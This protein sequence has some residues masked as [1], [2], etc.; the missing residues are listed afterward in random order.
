MWAQL[1]C[2]LLGICLMALPSLLGYGRP[3]ATSDWIIG[4]LAASWALVA[5]WEITRAVRWVNV[6]LAAWIVLS[7]VVLGAEM[8]GWVLFGHLVVGLSIGSLSALRGHRKHRFAGGWRAIWGRT[9]PG[10]Q[11]HLQP[12]TNEDAG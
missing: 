3:L 12:S 6:V 11:Q 9:P 2:A 10:E 1:T 4:P 8:S 5:A 7:P